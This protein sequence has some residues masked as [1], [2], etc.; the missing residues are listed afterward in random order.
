MTLLE[1]CVVVAT[2]FWCGL[3]LVKA[4]SHVAFAADI[5]RQAREAYRSYAASHAGE[6][7]PTKK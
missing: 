3:M 1:I 2:M 4:I 6:S 7:G 5:A